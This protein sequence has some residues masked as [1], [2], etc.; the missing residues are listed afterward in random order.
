MTTYQNQNFPVQ[1][2][3]FLGHR[4]MLPF[5]YLLTVCPLKFAFCC[6][7]IY[8]EQKGGDLSSI[9][10]HQALC[11]VAREMW[12]SSLHAEIFHFLDK[13]CNN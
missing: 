13:H 2:T 12:V 6:S 1:V 3:L 7:S 8:G 10:C 11:T 4:I 9:A 5:A